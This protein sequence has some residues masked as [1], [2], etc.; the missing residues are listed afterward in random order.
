MVYALCDGILLNFELLSLNEDWDMGMIPLQQTLLLF[1]GAESLEG[2][3]KMES[4]KK[5]HG[6]IAN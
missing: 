6:N 5:C 4:S 1:T 3:H 2:E